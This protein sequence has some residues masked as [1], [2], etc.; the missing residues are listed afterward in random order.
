MR[1]CPYCAEE[2]QQDAIKCSHCGEC[3]ERSTDQQ[4]KEEK[5]S[6]ESRILC[7]DGSCTGILDSNGVC[8]ECGRTSTEV[9]SSIKMSGDQI[10]ASQAQAYWNVSGTRILKYTMEIYHKGL[11]EHRLISAPETDMLE[12]KA[13]LQ[14]QKWIEKWENIESKRRIN[15]ERGANLEE[16]NSR[17]NTAIISLNQIDSL[18]THPLSIDYRVI[19]ESLKKKENYPEK[20]PTK[21]TQKK[22]KECPPKP[23]KQSAEFTPCFYF[24]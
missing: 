9:R 20:S 3:F 22:K 14:A 21:P 13:N 15:A 19:W 10:Q 8:T 5:Y 1:K 18:L 2:I 16:A 24:L 12:N 17:T 4:K 6:F 7:E 11:K 23:E